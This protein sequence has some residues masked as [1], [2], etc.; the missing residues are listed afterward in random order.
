MKQ[1]VILALPRSMLL[2]RPLPRRAIFHTFGASIDALL[3]FYRHHARLKFMI[4]T[5]ND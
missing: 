4:M 1:L 5:E 3:E 2:S